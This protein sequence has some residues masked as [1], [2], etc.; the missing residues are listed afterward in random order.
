M[1]VG[2]K[3]VSFLKRNH[4]NDISIDKLFRIALEKSHQGEITVHPYGFHI[5]KIRVLPEYQLRL[6][7]WL[8]GIRP[9]Q[10]PKWPPHDHNFD[11][12][13]MVLIGNMRHL[14]WKIDNSSNNQ[15]IIYEVAYKDNT[16]IL[17]K[18]DKLT[19]LELEKDE[20]YPC[21]HVYHFKRG[22]FHSIEIPFENVAATL[23]IASS[24]SDEPSRVFGE[25]GKL[26]KYEFT[27]SKVLPDSKDMIVQ[28]IEA[29]EKIYV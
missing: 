2:N 22:I 23:C 4:I 5:V 6:H 25:S 20:V 27:R 26:D 10:M 21:G 17:S 3:I 12:D 28:S 24:Y 8:K 19:G 29:L 16:S 11:I 7:I 1:L 13:S 18:S 15:G 9:M 14:T